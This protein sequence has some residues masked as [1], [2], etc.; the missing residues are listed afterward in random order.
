[1]IFFYNWLTLWNI[2]I[3]C[4]YRRFISCIHKDSWYIYKL[5]MLCTLIFV[6]LIRSSLTVGCVQPIKFS[7]NIDLMSERKLNVASKSCACIVTYRV[8]YMMQDV[9]SHDIIRYVVIVRTRLRQM[10]C[11]RACKL[12]YDL[13]W[14]KHCYKISMIKLTINNINIFS[15]IID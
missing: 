1:M 5:F 10:V 13:R 7:L 6:S 2:K 11:V 8:P 3:F 9:T 4:V 12:N 15:L 14:Y